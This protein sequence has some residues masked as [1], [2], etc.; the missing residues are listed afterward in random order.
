[1]GIF[2]EFLP[3]PLTIS[4]HSVGQTF[5]AFEAFPLFVLLC[6]RAGA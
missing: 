3:K 6:W 5:A 1:M 2:H 4:N